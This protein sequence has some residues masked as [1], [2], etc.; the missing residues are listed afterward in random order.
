MI[1][2]NS[3]MLILSVAAIVSLLILTISNSG[4]KVFKFGVSF[5]LFVTLITAL[6]SILVNVVTLSP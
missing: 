4:S 6:S 2:L 3:M 5:Y 1:T